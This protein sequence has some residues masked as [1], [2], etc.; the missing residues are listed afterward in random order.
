MDA[1]SGDAPGRLTIEEIELL[2][3]ARRAG[4]RAL[5]LVADRVRPG[6][7]S[8]LGGAASPQEEEIR[9]RND[10]SLAFPLADVEGVR[11]VTIP[12]EAGTAGVP[13]RVLQITTTFLGLTGTVSPLPPHVAEEVAQ[14]VAEGGEARTAAFLDLFHHRALSFFHRAGAKHDVAAG[15]LS[16]Q[17][18]DWSRRMLALVG[19]D[20][21]DGASAGDEPRWRALRYAPLLVERA[22]TA[23]ALEA[24]LADVLGGELHGGG[25][26]VEQFVGSWVALAPDE[27]T[28]VG[29]SATELGRSFVLG[30]RV[31]DRA[32]RIRVVLGPLDADGYVRFSAPERIAG[33]RRTVRALAGGDLDLEIA[34]RLAPRAAPGFVLSSSGRNRLG[35]NTWLG[36]Q[37]AEMQVVVDAPRAPGDP[38]LVV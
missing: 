35:R 38:A 12:A 22:L 20:G 23:A 14:E 24:C 16:D 5:M 31:F 13:R 15:A 21:E 28:R 36:H 9:L 10:P 32:G 26:A 37:S 11:V 1:E 17:S 8:A 18:D 19:R 7:A 25:V 27:R 29:R 6:A 3:D 34:L 4:F 2:A 30:A 33:L